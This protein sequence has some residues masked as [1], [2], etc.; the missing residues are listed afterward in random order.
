M[1]NDKFKILYDLSYATRGKSG[2]PGDT[3]SVA[4]LLTKQKNFGVDFV[5]FPRSY[6][7]NSSRRNS[8]I[9]TIAEYLGKAIRPNPG[10][11]IIPR[12]MEKILILLQGINPIR[13]MHLLEVPAS[14]KEKSFKFLGMSLNDNKNN[15]FVGTIATPS[16]FARPQ[17]NR[18]FKLPTKQFDFFIQQQIDPIT[19]SKKTIHIVRL[20]DILPITHPE[21]FD[22]LAVNVFA[23][24]LKTMMKNRSL[25]WVLD[26]KINSLEFSSIF[27]VNSSYIPCEVGRQFTNFDI[28]QKKK[29]Q[30]VMV[31]TIEP[32]KQVGFVVSSYMRYRETSKSRTPLKLVIM[33]SKGWQED[34]LWNELVEGDYAPEIEFY[35]S[36]SNDLIQK[37]LQ[38]SKFVL[39]ASLAE[40]FG[41]PPLEGMLFGCVPVVSRIPQHME[42]IGQKGIYF[43]QF[44]NESLIKSL[45]I[46][47]GKAPSHK[48]SDSLALSNFVKTNFGEDRVKNL[49]SKLLIELHTVKK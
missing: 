5:L 2:I 39:S 22:D 44:D 4:S 13:N 20:H 19:T 27:G 48:Y 33:G 7:R 36:P 45:F 46:A 21:Y 35:P 16:R 41:L 25:V 17:W 43:N 30:I 34:K 32:R 1:I 6:V 42:N 49:W 37:K 23:R 8:E 31:N 9:Y 40:G 14:M 15:L 29:N 3:R 18:M 12:N 24:G 47:E 11:S 28:R 26:S 38:E 10:R